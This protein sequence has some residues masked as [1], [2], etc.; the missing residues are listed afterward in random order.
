MIRKKK[1]SIVKNIYNKNKN[2][3][4]K[5]YHKKIYHITIKNMTSLLRLWYKK[6]ISYKNK[7]NYVP[8]Q[9]FNPVKNLVKISN[10]KINNINHLKKIKN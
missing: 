2:K 7:I 8:I 3:N 1:N 4:K 5:K 9:V 10:K 6:K